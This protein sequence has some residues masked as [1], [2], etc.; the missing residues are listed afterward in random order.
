MGDV[1][2]AFLYESD[3]SPRTRGGVFASVTLVWFLIFKIISMVCLAGCSKSF[4]F[5]PSASQGK[6]GK[7]CPPRWAFPLPPF[8]RSGCV[9]FVGDVLVVLLLWGFYV[10]CCPWWGMFCLCSCV[11]NCRVVF[12]CGDGSGR[13]SL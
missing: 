3:A 13:G 5:S 12:S 9:F 10:G 7:G 2:L 8:T 1:M 4:T 11:G 6:N